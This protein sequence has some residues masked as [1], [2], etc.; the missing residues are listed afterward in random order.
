MQ[1]KTRTRE[2]VIASQSVAHVERCIVA[3]GHT[4]E[5]PSSDYGHDLNMATFGANGAVENGCIYFQ[6]KATDSLT[7]LKDEST[8]PFSIDWRD[9]AFWRG[10]TMPVILIVHDAANDIAYWLYTQEQFEADPRYQVAEASGTI[11]VYLSRDRVLDEQAIGRFRDFKQI[12][13]DQLQ[14]KVR[15][16]E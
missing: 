8:I 3:A 9:V 1:R 4:A 7:V 5:R 13:L 14:G 10:E 16:H 11:T 12:V 2:H 6:I 15:H